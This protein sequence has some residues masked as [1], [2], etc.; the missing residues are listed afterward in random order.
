MQRSA[1]AIICRLSVMR[2]YCDKPLKLG[3]C[4]FHKNV[5][6]CFNSLPAKFDDEIRM[7]PLDLGT[8]S[9]VRWFS[10]S[11]RYISETVR[12]RA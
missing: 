11:R 1:I 7:G 9:R 4:N 6:Q 3:S 12:D 8:K 5:A 2:V 10:T